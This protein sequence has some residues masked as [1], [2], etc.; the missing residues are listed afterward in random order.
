LARLKDLYKK[1]IIPAMMEQ[2]SYKNVNMVPKMNKVVINVGVG[3]AV[4]NSKAI[5]SVVNEITQISG[6]KPIVTKAKKSIATFKLREG[7]PI[8]VKV[9]LRG[10]RMYEFLDRFI[11][12][13]LPRVR[14]FKGISV[15]GFD[16]RGNYTVGIKEQLIFP[17]IDYDKVDKMRGMNIT[18]ITTA[19][20]DEEAKELLV[21]FGAPFAKI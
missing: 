5:E 18:F 19:K 14:D 1:D 3:E 4:Q 2:F 7:M 8:G 21:K 10:E 6:Q 9:T 20:T 13:S 15:K 12:A 11:N 17:E 16:G